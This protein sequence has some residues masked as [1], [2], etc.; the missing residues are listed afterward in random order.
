MENNEFD[1]EKALAR[2]EEIVTKLEEGKSSLAESLKLYEEGV[3]LSTALQKKLKDVE[4]QTVK[5]F[6]NGKEVDF[7]ENK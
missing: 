5:I 1:F 7:N 2:L 6:E 3:G 4:V